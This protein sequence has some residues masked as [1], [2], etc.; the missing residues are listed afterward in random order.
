MM[1]V[2]VVAVTTHGG[3]AAGASPR[4]LAHMRPRD[5]LLISAAIGVRNPPTSYL[6]CALSLPVL[7]ATVQGM[8]NRGASID[9]LSQYPHEKE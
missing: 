9:W 3:A 7:A 2:A 1:A 8:V 6:R 5:F 4:H